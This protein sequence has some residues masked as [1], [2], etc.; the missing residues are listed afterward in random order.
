MRYKQATIINLLYDIY[1]LCSQKKLTFLSLPQE[2]ER[3]NIINFKL[4]QN[5]WKSQVSNI[6]ISI[7]S[8][9]GLHP[10]PLDLVENMILSQSFPLSEVEFIFIEASSSSAYQEYFSSKSYPC[11]ITVI[12]GC[13]ARGHAQNIGIKHSTGEIIY[14][15]ADDFILPRKAIQSHWDFHQSSTEIEAVGIG[16]GLIPKAIKNNFSHWLESSGNL[17]GVP[18]YKSMKCVPDH[19]FYIGNTSIKRSFLD[20]VGLFDES[21]YGESWDDYEFGLRLSKQGLS[22]KYIKDATALHFHNISESLRFKEV[23][24]SGKNAYLFKQLFPGIYDWEHHINVPAWEYYLN[25]AKSYILFWITKKTAH[26]HTLWSHLTNYHFKK[27]YV[28]GSKPN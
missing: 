14:F 25:I 17:F 18:F 15:V 13:K 16:S 28:K 23:E 7:I 4:P 11:T 3:F 21:F 24:K 26:Q 5:S 22:A 9:V 2:Y 27:G 8:Y 20:K 6:K 12:S 1:S 19:F 10:L